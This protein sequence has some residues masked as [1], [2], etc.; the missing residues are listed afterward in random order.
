MDDR[1]KLVDE[2]GKKGELKILVCR[3]NQ[4]KQG[5]NRK[6]A[7]RRK[8]LGAKSRVETLK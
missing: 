1:A 6:G 7:G 3:R 8:A 4:R 2:A 5:G